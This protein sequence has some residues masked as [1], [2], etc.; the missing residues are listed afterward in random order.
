MTTRFTG[1]RYL[2]GGQWYS[3]L[4]N[5]AGWFDQELSVSV[6][7]GVSGTISWTQDGDSWAVTGAAKASGTVAWT[8]DEDTW[9]L[10][11][12]VKASGS[13]SWTQD[14]DAWSLTGSIASP[15]PQGGARYVGGW[16]DLPTGRKR[17]KK[18]WAEAL[19]LLPVK[20]Q[21]VVVKVVEEQQDEPDEA[22]WTQALHRA[23]ERKNI[24]Y[25]ALYAEILKQR[26]RA[27]ELERQEEEEV[28]LLLL[29]H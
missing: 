7:S 13:I 10:T 4:T 1:D 3:R 28:A 11:A 8:Q 25:R 29:M 20:V 26:L 21:R 6:V 15:A 18:E 9:A 23:L 27:I 2:D 19:G 16:V 14:D 22:K 12:S 24:A 5:A 17:S